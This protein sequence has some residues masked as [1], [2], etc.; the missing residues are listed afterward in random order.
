MIAEHPIHENLDSANG[1][2]GWG[3]CVLSGLQIDNCVNCCIVSNV[4]NSLDDISFML[5]S[6]IIDSGT[7]RNEIDRDFPISPPAFYR[8]TFL[9]VNAL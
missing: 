4:L 3:D 5:F 6:N 7:V 9:S 2:W 8:S 1:F